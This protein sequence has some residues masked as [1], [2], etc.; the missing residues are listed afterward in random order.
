[1]SDDTHRHINTV[2]ETIRTVK[3]RMRVTKITATRCIKTSRGE[4]FNGM[5][6]TWDGMEEMTLVDARVAHLLLAMEAAIGAWRS[7]RME[8]AI[9]PQEFEDGVKALKRNTVRELSEIIPSEEAA[10]AVAEAVPLAKW[11]S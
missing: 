1:M 5:T 6:A 4:F 7:A 10:S 8:K 9:T 11:G 3:D 2:R